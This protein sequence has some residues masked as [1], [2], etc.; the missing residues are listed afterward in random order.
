MKLSG[1]AFKFLMSLLGV[2]LLSGLSLHLQA[3]DYTLFLTRHAEKLPATEDN[4]DPGLSEKGKQRAQSFVTLLESQPIVSV[5]STDYLRTRQTA[6]P[7]AEAL[8]VNLQ[9]YPAN[10]P[11]ALVNLLQ[12][13]RENAFIVGHSNTIPRLVSLLGGVAEDDISEEEYDRLYQLD[14]NTDGKV[15]T[16]LIRWHL[17]DDTQP[18]KPRSKESSPFVVT[19]IAE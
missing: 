14:I 2:G 19:Q 17:P 16:Q 10:S 5:Y 6:T 7:M 13:K 11:A 3:S 1:Y 4:A 12:S 18:D 9:I 15:T 8:T